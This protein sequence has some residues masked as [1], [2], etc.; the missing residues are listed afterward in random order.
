MRRVF[1]YGFILIFISG[2]SLQTLVRANNEYK[3]DIKDD[4]QSY[5]ATGCKND[6][7]QVKNI[8]NY[9]PIVSRSI[10]YTTG[11][12][13]L[14][15]Y[16]ESVWQETPSKSIKSSIIKALRE[17]HIFKDVVSNR[18]SIQPDYVLEYSVEN[19]MQHFSDDQKSSYVDVKIHFSFIKYKTS[20]LLY[21]TT[22][23]KKLPSASLD[24][25]GGVKSIS[26]ALNDVILQNSLWLDGVC[27]ED[28][29]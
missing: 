20:K 14:S 11:E 4:V 27:K 13:E 16:T 15:T 10:Y 18:S 2:C 9:N 24:A 3:L 12:Y 6:V 23:E 8:E 5:S 21:S 25:I 19:L 17:T 7:V 29:K 22:I 1:F 28:L 26:S